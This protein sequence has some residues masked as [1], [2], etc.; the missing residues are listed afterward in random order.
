MPEKPVI[1]LVHG[2]W[3]QPLHFR[4]LIK[5]LQARGFSVLAP[6]LATTASDDSVD[7]KTHIDDMKRI[8]ESI[9]PVMTKAGP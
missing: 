6:T 4:S 9:L 8:H 1:L 3:H 2:A 5:D 7:G